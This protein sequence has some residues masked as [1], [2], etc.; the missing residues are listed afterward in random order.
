[1]TGVIGL[2]GTITGVQVAEAASIP[3]NATEPLVRAAVDHLKS[4]RLEPARGE[5]RF[6]LT[7]QYTNDAS[8]PLGFTSVRYS[9]PTLITITSNP[10][11]SLPRDR[12]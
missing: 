11:T 3:R 6:R 12:W 9:L 4:L 1:M 7:Y 2:D 8:K 10:L 5:D